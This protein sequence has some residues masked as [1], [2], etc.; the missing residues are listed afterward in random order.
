MEGILEAATTS[1]NGP[2]GLELLRWGYRIKNNPLT[3]Y[4]KMHEAF[5]DMVWMPWPGKVCLFVYHPDQIS[6]V[7]KEN[8][9]NYSK[10]NQYDELKPLLGEGLL[11]SEGELW[12]KERR[13]MAKQFHGAAIDEY[14]KVISAVTTEKLNDLPVGEVDV[15]PVFNRLA[16]DLA[17]QIFFG[18]DVEHFS[19]SISQGLTYEMEKVNERM[20]S[21]FSFP[22]AFPT[23]ENLRR[24]KILFDMDKVVE[25]IM[26]GPSD[27]KTNILSSLM[28]SGDL[29]KKQIR[30]EVMT[31]LMAGH[32]TTSNLLTWVAWYLALHPS[33]QE[34]I[35]K[36]MDGTGK[37]VSEIGRA[38]FL[39]LPRLKAVIDE[40]LRLM[41]PVPA[42]ARMTNETDVIGGVTVPAGVTV[43]C[44][45]WVTQRD[46]R[47][48]K[49]PLTWNPERFIE[50]QVLRDDCTFFPFA[51]GPRACIG[52]ELARAEAMLIV[53][54]LVQNFEWSLSPGFVPHPV[55]HLTLQSKNGMKI[56]LKKRFS[57]DRKVVGT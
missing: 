36:E 8:H 4:Q 50:R 24:R 30:D 3:T 25:K 19:S 48:W 35:R 46:A 34:E 51:R 21:A 10:G 9:T 16:L 14:I 17:G 29:P 26:S 54:A 12:R 45:P 37:G 44:Q 52:E 53:A 41:P 7:L 27:N 39:S 20:R 11:T 42:F 49:D 31:L 23:P 57:V 2:K 1:L 18:A 47:W 13:I 33:W 15:S 22:L 28:K 40:T 5:G 38:D 32:E 43:V 6:Y 56:V 55:H